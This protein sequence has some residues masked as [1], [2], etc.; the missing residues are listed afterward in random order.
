[1]NNPEIMKGLKFLIIEDN[2]SNLDHLSRTL[3]YNTGVLGENVSE[4]ETA[5]EAI[6][7]ISD[8]EPDIVLLDLKVPRKSGDEPSIESAVEILKEIELQYHRKNRFIRVI[9]IS[10]SVQDAGVQQ[11]IRGDRSNI[12]KFVDKNAIAIDSDEFKVKLIKLIERCIQEEEP[13]RSIEYSDLR[14]S[15]IKKHLLKLSPNL[16]QK[17]EKEILSDFESLNDRKVNVYNRVKSIIL[18]CGEVVEDILHLIDDEKY[19]LSEKKYSDDDNTIRKKLL[20][21]TGRRHL[22]KDAEGKDKGYSIDAKNILISRVACDCAFHAYRYRSEAVHGKE[23]DVLNNKLFPSDYSF[24][25]EDAAISINL[26]M[27]LINDYIKHLESKQ[28]KK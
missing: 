20:K 8:F 11:L 3:L 28:K 12:V 25:R 26:I 24:T 14:N 27:P 7:I 22:G 19:D 2:K 18:A 1:M 17:I 9:V 16:W 4:A 5:E 23:G 21:I 13:E 10:G 6:E 15:H